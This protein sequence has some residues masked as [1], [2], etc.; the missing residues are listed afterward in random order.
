MQSLLN[1]QGA[2]TTFVG[3]CCHPDSRLWEFRLNLQRLV[4]GF[5]LL[6]LYRSNI[7]HLVCTF[8]YWVCVRYFLQLLRSHSHCLLGL[9]D[10]SIQLLTCV[11]NSLL[12]GVMS[13]MLFPISFIILQCPYRPKLPLLPALTSSN[14]L[15]RHKTQ[16][17]S[18]LPRL[19]L[20]Q[21]LH[22]R[23]L[24]SPNC[25]KYILLPYMY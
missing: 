23:S 20:C 24:T 17:R 25:D 8:F 6:L 13:V 16:R 21:M 4:R 1:C 9:T 2:H 15:L 5:I 19:C 22:K 12:W 7:L 14:V 11:L 10:L 3:L 18:L